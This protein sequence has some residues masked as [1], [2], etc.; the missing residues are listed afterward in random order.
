MPAADRLPRRSDLPGPG[1]H[2]HLMG[3]GGAGM[4]G[5]A[6]LLAGAG[7]R[8]SGCD[9]GPVDRPGDLRERRVEVVGDH[10]PAHV[11]GCALL[12][13]SSA[14][15]PAHPEVE[16]ARAAA[17][18]V[19]SRA[20]AL[21]ALVNDRK[22]VAV[23]GTHGKTTV[24]AMTALACAA[25]G[26]DPSAAVGGRV[27]EWDGYARVGGGPISIVEADEYDRSFLE[28][29]P[30]LM[31]LT[32]L[33]PE[34]VE[35]YGSFEAVE[36]AYRELADRAAGREGLLYC[37]DDPGARRVGEPLARAADYGFD[38]E[39]YRLER[40]GDAAPDADGRAA[41]VAG[42]GADSGS[43]R[44]RLTS[45]E[46][47]LSFR[48]AVPGIH[49]ARNAAGA[50]AAALALGA[51]PERLED[52][53]EGFAGVGRR[54]EAV[55]SGEDVTIIDDY[56][57]HPTEVAASL[58]A[59]R[60]RHPG[61]RVVVVFQPHLYSRT[62]AFAAEFAEALRRADLALV[63][64]IYPAREEPIPGVTA[65]L[66]LEAA[67]QPRRAGRTGTPTVPGTA[68]RERAGEIRK[69]T[70]EEAGDTEWIVELSREGPLVVVYMGAGDV[71][72]LARA[73]ASEMART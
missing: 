45:P 24:T 44:F 29:D 65:D 40:V 55:W 28:L 27:P 68:G 26:L 60:G 63:L 9:H 11:E 37:A 52:A 35:S 53:L 8:V 21:G 64:P 38:A 42:R 71:T 23:S 36:A 3:V 54:L 57:H 20:R 43:P 34:H 19:M 13:R 15:P 1:S 31:V 12:V 5:L 14:V 25:A 50:L 47:E 59:V 6:T 10:D 33:E 30:S 4:R 16:A 70:A 39:V 18:P 46:S 72:E 69:T 51:S 61:R 17:V 62:R 7:Y 73:V 48:L 58:S 32:S 41:P 67:E 66:L 22:L 49:N 56:A 2:V